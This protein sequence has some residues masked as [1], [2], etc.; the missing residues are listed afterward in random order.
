MI[1]FD[2]LEFDLGTIKHG[3]TKSVVVNINNSGSTPV[4]FTVANAS[5]SCTSGY[6]EYSTLQPKSKGTFKISFNS[7]KVYKGNNLN[8]SIALNYKI[9]RDSFSQIFRLK[10]N[11]V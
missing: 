3:V 6:V 11:V 8:K 2:N 4:E 5:C 9:G 10:A 7:N 1:T